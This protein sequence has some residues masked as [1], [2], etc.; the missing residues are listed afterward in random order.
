MTGSSLSWLPKPWDPAAV[1]EFA[2]AHEV[3]QRS[4]G[5]SI[6]TMDVFDLNTSLHRRR[7]GRHD[8]P[9]EP[10]IERRRW[11]SRGTGSVGGFAFTACLQCCRR[12][13]ACLPLVLAANAA[14]ADPNV[15]ESVRQMHADGYGLVQMVG[16]L[17]LDD[18]MS[19][20]IRQ[21]VE[22]LSQSVVDGI[23]QATVAMLDTSE[24]AM[25]LDCRVTEA[26][27]TSGAPVEVDVSP[28]NGKPTI[29]VRQQSEA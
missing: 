6:N 18:E 27:I 26:Q 22:E 24:F 13:G 9:K 3:T 1:A 25:P 14:L 29:R 8:R 28:E 15:R 23:R 4:E 11:K 7:Q 12:T 21:I 10:G 16:A 2:V 20:R 5:R 19:D 17:G